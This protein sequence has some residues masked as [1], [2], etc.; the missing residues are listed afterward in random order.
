MASMREH[1]E[2]LD[3]KKWA[4]LTRNAAVESIETSRRLG[5]QPRPETVTLAAMTEAKLAEHR[6][7]NGPGKKRASAV[8]Q[9]VEADQR[10]READSRARDAHQGRLDAEA[11]AAIARADADE[12]ARTATAARERVRAVEADSAEKDQ[13]RARER[14]ADQ[15]AS[16]QAIAETERIRGEAAAA[17]EQARADAAAEITA[18]QERVRAAD[19]RAQQRAA[20]RTAERSAGETALQ[21]LHVQLE[22]VRADAAAEVAAAQERARAA[23]ARAEQRVTERAAE[24]AAGEEAVALLRKES[25]QV[26]ADAAAEVAAARGQASGEVTAAR[27]AA[28]ADV[29]AARQAAHLEIE[30]VRRAAQAEID[31]AHRYADDVTRL[32]QSEVARA[33]ATAPASRLLT[34]PIAPVE[35]RGHI[36]RIEE[37]LDALYQIDYMLEIGL[38]AQPPPDVDFVRSL[39]RTVQERVTGLSDEFANLPARFTD[40]SLTEAATSYANAAG[41]AY[42]AFLQRIEGAVHR[43]QDRAFGPAA[44]IIEAVSTML[45]DPWVQALR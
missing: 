1:V 17:T 2:D 10:S 28:E 4:A 8:M 32:A 42:R 20:E 9:L 29:A 34:I 15:Q 39:A 33:M 13:R 14:A 36:R 7:L 6:E 24:R 35:V 44:V 11:A 45:A 37:V 38:A 26:R 16:Q 27:Q 41:G 40:Q 12:S 30:A 21:Q 25:E 31:D 18:A 43:L 22:Q 23:E 3:A 5:L 19:A